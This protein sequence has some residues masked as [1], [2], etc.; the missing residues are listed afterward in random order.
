MVRPEFVTKA[1][2][3]G[4]V[5]IKGKPVSFFSPP[6]EEAD[7][8]WVDLEQLAQVFV[9]EDAAK[10]LVKHSHNFGVAS[11]PTEA[12]VRDGK[13]VTIVPHPMA[14]GFCAFIDQQEGHIE[15]QEDEWSLGPANLEY[16]KAFADAHSKFMP[17]SFEALAAAYRNQGGPHIRGAE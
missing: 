17:L 9:P 2:F 3:V 16:V 12:A 14:Q 4:V 10:R 7:F 11:R 5:E 6:H 13:I 1:R 15:L 8:L